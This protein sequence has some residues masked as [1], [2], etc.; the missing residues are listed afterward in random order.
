MSKRS[1]FYSM[2]NS[3]LLASNV[4]VRSK[5]IAAALVFLLSGF[6]FFA[7]IGTTEIE[8]LASAGVGGWLYYTASLFVFGGT[9]LGLPVYKPGA[10]FAYVALYSSYFL[11]PLVTTSFVAEALLSLVRSTEQH[12]MVLENHTVL[13][14][15]GDF[16]NAYRQA[17]RK[18]S[19]DKQLLIVRHDEDALVGLAPDY[20]QSS[21]NIIQLHTN[22][23][24]KNFAAE[25]RLSEASEVICIGGD[26]LVNLEL[27]W[28]FSNAN[29]KISIAAHVADLTL[30]RRVSPIIR[31]ARQSGKERP[32][33]VFSTHRIASFQLFDM[34]LTAH[35]DKTPDR[36]LLIIAGLGRFAE[37][38]LELVSVNAVEQIEKVVLVAP[39]ANRRLRQLSADISFLELEIECVDGK[40][41]DPRT[42]D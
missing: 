20:T 26:D 12:R 22:A 35:F 6:G 27:A 23:F 32:P 2:V 16:A 15:E 8:V 9:D 13:L 42:W 4:S 11:A 19:P 33:G 3:V 7:G 17:I 41:E 38:M 29:P 5:A 39:D 10:A 24:D 36:D 37:T 34:S 25:L 30:L 40:L 14:G 21:D 18:V 31:S 1:Y 28:Q